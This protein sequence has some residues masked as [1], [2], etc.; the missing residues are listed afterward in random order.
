MTRVG[1]GAHTEGRPDDLTVAWVLVGAT[2]EADGKD[3]EEGDVA[4]IVSRSI[5]KFFQFEV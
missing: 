1:H 3:G 5:E 2:L 4:H